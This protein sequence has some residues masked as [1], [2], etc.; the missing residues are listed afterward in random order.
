MFIEHTGFELY[1]IPLKVCGLNSLFLKL[2]RG[3]VNQLPLSDSI[4]TVTTLVKIMFS[5]IFYVLLSLVK[6]GR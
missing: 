5:N 6:M 3:V 1:K 4:R 2:I